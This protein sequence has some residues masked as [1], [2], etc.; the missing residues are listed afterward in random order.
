MEVLAD[1]AGEH[2][3][4][5]HTLNLAVPRTK[6]R[7][8]PSRRKIPELLKTPADLSAAPTLY[9]MGPDS[10][11]QAPARPSWPEPKSTSHNQMGLK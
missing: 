7:A 5:G 2:R 8:A 6:M 9:L 4:A 3:G 11:G 10:R 1:E